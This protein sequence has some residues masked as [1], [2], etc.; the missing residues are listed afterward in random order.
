MLQGA[1]PHA[2]PGLVQ[3]LGRRWLV[4]QNYRSPCGMDL[5]TKDSETERCQLTSHDGHYSLRYAPLAALIDLY[6]SD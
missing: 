6:A 2:G 3:P 1:N 5:C 4:F